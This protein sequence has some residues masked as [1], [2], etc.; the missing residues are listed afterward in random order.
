MGCSGGACNAECTSGAC[1]DTVGETFY[2]T[3]HQCGTVPTATEYQCAGINCGDDAQVRYQ[4]QYCSGI[5]A[6]CDSSNLVWHG[7]ETN[8]DC[9]LDQLCDSSSSDSWCDTCEFGCSGSTCNS[10]ACTLS[11]NEPFNSSG[12]PSGWTVENYDG[13]GYGYQWVWSNASNTTGSSGGYW[14]CDSDYTVNFDDRLYSATYNRGD[15]SSVLLSFNHDYS[16]YDG[17]VGY[18][19]LQVNSGSWTTLTSYTSSTSG[20]VSIDLTSY[21]PTG[22]SFRIRYRYV[23]NY[24]WYWKV[25]NFTIT[26]S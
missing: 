22:A 17:D 25:D 15:C 26:G 6:D 5:T 1:C 8:V 16:Y 12:L 11:I 13:D 14:W 9:A 4:Y 3:D 21:I 23:A 24:D 7:W 2:P 18:L 10:S 20:Y 19:Q